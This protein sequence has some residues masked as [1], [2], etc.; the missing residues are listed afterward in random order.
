MT[1]TLRTNFNLKNRVMAQKLLDGAVRDVHK[2]LSELTN[3]MTA[4]ECKISD[5]NELITSQNQTIISLKKTIEGMQQRTQTT[6]ADSKSTTQRPLRQARLNST[7]K[8]AVENKSAAA[9]ASKRTSL[10]TG[11]RTPDQSRAESMTSQSAGAT[12]KVTMTT[13]SQDCGV[14]EQMSTVTTENEW[15]TASKNKKSKKLS[16]IVGSGGEN[17]ELQSVETLK[18]LQVWSLKP[19]TTTNNIL[20]HINKIAKS[21]AYVVNKR[22]IKTNRHASFVIGTPASLYETLISETAWPQG[23]RLSEWYFHSRPRVERGNIGLD[24]RPVADVTASK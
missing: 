13:A 11:P 21:D 9:A 1:I 17:S 18:Y 15:K 23:V 2:V 14:T 3:R 24:A 22:E 12:T 7:G 5:Q 4:L 8:V 6:S 16:V 10:V 19:E 20:T